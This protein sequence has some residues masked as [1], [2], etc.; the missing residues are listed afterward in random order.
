MAILTVKAT[1]Q[2]YISLGQL[3]IPV[4]LYSAV[5]SVRP[6]FI[7]LHETDGSPVERE[8]R[9]RAEGRKIE[10]SEVVRAIEVKPGRYVTITDHELGVTAHSPV[11]TISVQQ[12]SE[13]NAIPNVYIDKPYYVVP[14]KGG[15]RAY[16]LLREVL[17]RLCKVAIGQ[18]VIYNQE[19]IACAYIYGDLI[20]LQQLHFAAEIV[21]RQSIKSPALPKPSPSEIEALS[22][23]VQRFSGPLYLEDY[24][25]EHSEH[26]RELVERK[27][28]GLAAPREERIAP[29]AT[30]ETDIIAALHD[31]L[32]AR[33]LVDNPAGNAHLASM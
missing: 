7:Q 3:G 27:A 28:K 4:R 5:Q 6:R 11:K 31:T 13:P 20:M 8:L 23:V 9:C 15:E 16:A 21:P 10:S 29:H 18:F 30:P 25:D 33:R 12:F 2:G 14:A 17:A 32:G 1:W 24:H 22:A 19:R 26:I